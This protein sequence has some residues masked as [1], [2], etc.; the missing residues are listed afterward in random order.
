MNSKRMKF[1]ASEDVPQ[2]DREVGPSRQQVLRLVA[3][4]LIERVQK[5]GHTAMMSVQNLHC[6][7]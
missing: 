6:H 2:H 1:G 4:A 3:S 7:I 5:T